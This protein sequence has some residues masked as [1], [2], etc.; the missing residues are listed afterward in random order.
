[1]SIEAVVGMVGEGAAVLVRRALAAAGLAPDTP[2]ALDRFL[3][4]Y[5]KRLTVFTRPYPGIPEALDTLRAGG[6]ALAVLTNKPQRPSEEILRQLG[7]APRFS[8]VLGGDTAAGRKPDPGG[9]LQII[10]R[11]GGTPGETVLVGDSPFDL[12]T[13]RNAGTQICLTRF[14]FGF[15][16]TGDLFLGDELFVDSAAELPSVLTAA[17]SARTTRGGRKATP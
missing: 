7:L 15:Q 9:L 8:D 2:G 12:R 3:V 1:L 17:F 5:E 13:A 16:F 4:Q 11:A 6:F 14:G 10:E